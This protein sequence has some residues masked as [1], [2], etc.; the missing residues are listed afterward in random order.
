MKKIRKVLSVLLAAAL[1]CAVFVFP[2]GAETPADEKY[3]RLMMYRYGYRLDRVEADMRTSD[4]AAYSFADDPQVADIDVTYSLTYTKEET[5]LATVYL[6]TFTSEELNAF[7]DRYS[8]A[9]DVIHLSPTGYITADEDKFAVLV[10]LRTETDL[11]EPLPPMDFTPADFDAGT[12]KKVHPVTAVT[13]LSTEE[14]EQLASAGKTPP[15][16]GTV[17]ALLLELSDSFGF[18]TESPAAALALDLLSFET[19]DRFTEKQKALLRER[20]VDADVVEYDAGAEEW[21]NVGE[22][23]RMRVFRVWSYGD[24]DFSALKDVRERRACSDGDATVWYLFTYDLSDQALQ[25][26]AD[27]L[28]GM[29]EVATFHC[30][31]GVDYPAPLKKDAQEAVYYR[32]CVLM[33]GDADRDRAITAA[34]ARLALR[35]AVRLDVPSDVLK[36]AMDTDGDGKVTA[37][38]ARTLLR[39]AVGLETQQT[40][41]MN[42]A[43]GK[44]LLT[45]PFRYREGC[46]WHVTVTEGDGAKLKIKEVSAD[47]N[48]P[49][50]PAGEGPDLF[51]TVMPYAAGNYTLHVE[52]TRPGQP[53]VLQAFDIP[54]GVYSQW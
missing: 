26:I 16:Q 34:D 41:R 18:M 44:T 10:R 12:V 15:A 45:G 46:V 14:T 42:L 22:L 39:I 33:P 6:K 51:Y 23:A 49:V 36:Y 35:T 24:P 11:G 21:D 53:E 5:W 20:F 13:A 43:P 19:S 28:N 38:D 8:G 3:G 31:T 32:N 48:P 17:C 30:Y 29:P 2:G 7:I 47:L 25:S 50:K 54:I 27:T 40:L 9:P 37:N 52:Q 4:A 1:L